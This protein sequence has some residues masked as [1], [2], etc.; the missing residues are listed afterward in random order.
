MK[1]FPILIALFVPFVV[2]KGEDSHRDATQFEDLEKQHGGSRLG[3][4]ASDL[5]TNRRVDYRADERFIMCSTFKVLAV[6]AVLK[7]ADENKEKLD[8]FI[9]YGE[10]Q[11]L[12]YAPVTRA[13]V[14]EGGMTLEALCAAAISL[15]DNTAANLL[16]ETIG[17][18]KGLT[19]FARSLGDDVTRLDRMEPE[20]NRATPGDDR[21]T[22]APA[23][24][25][26]DLQRLLTSDVLSQKSRA[27]LEGWM[28]GNETGSK[29]IRASVPADWR[30]G[31][32]TG[33]SGNGASNDIAIIR[34]P[35]GGPLFL[36]IYVNAPSESSEGRD[37]LVA[38][39]AKIALELL[40]K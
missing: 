16:L 29:M 8:R 32:K 10:A 15:S 26:K 14:N 3:V 40:K 13:H 23:A 11:L 1:F 33:R 17:G 12:E 7:R 39:A 36:A 37:L 31:D 21:D 4:T 19:D 22:T 6:A 5:S 28:I 25:C 2:A 20:L 9:G 24:M 27:L 38:D 18:P 30:V 35:T 34:P